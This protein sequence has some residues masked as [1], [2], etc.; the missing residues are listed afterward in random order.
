MY[1]QSHL[2]VGATR[3]KPL[4]RQLAGKPARTPQVDRGLEA[5]DQT[6]SSPLAWIGGEFA[7]RAL[8]SP[9]ERRKWTADSRRLVNVQFSPRLERR[10]VCHPPDRSDYADPA[11][12]ITAPQDAEKAFCRLRVRANVVREAAGARHQQ[13]LHDMIQRR[14]PVR[15]RR[16]PS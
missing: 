11:F 2:I 4:S 12:A 8:A 10:R 14:L 16:S 1:Q 15:S 3:P 7:I 5:I 13:R 9:H 6:C